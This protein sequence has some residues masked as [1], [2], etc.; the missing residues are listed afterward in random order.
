MSQ[1][2]PELFD[3]AKIEPAVSKQPDLTKELSRE[4]FYF[5]NACSTVTWLVNGLCGRCDSRRVK[6]CPP[7]R[8]VE[9]PD[10]PT[11]AVSNDWHVGTSKNLD[12]ACRNG[13]WFC[14]SCQRIT[15]LDTETGPYNKCALCGSPRIKWHEPIP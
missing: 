3:L 7:L 15:N 5:C 13:F 8:G 2:Q 14:R 12:R 4:G 1:D 10:G 11:R 9:L 6:W